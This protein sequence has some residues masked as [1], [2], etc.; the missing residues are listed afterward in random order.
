MHYRIDPEWEPYI[1]ITPYDVTIDTSGHFTYAEGQLIKG[2]FGGLL[3]RHSD[4]DGFRLWLHEI[5]L[6]Q[7]IHLQFYTLGPTA[8]FIYMLDGRLCFAGDEGPEVFAESGFY[9]L[10]YLP[11]GL[12]PAYLEKGKHTIIQLELSQDL[13]ERV[14]LKHI[15]M[16][17]AWYSLTEQAEEG[18]IHV[19]SLMTEEVNN[20]LRRML[21]CQIEEKERELH[22]YARFIDL[23]LLY[24]EYLNNNSLVKTSS[25]YRFTHDDF[26]AIRAASKLK[27]ENIDEYISAKDM[28]DEALLH[29]RKLK[30]GFKE[31]YGMTL[32]DWV[33]EQKLQHASDQLK[34]TNKTL[35]QI[36]VAC[37]YRTVSALI[38]AF[39]K[40][41]GTTP[42]AYRK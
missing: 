15:E 38:K 2:P 7:P 42:A 9:Y 25:G 22:Q 13:L 4:E 33:V 6:I 29:H 19:A 35:L 27:L 17:Q 14:A 8:S 41:F 1:T 24:A 26:A 31:M 20:Q 30:A 10:A 11:K 39:K 23:W 36:A 3:K 32:K 18:F 28:A 16:F 40:R 12:M 37:G 21:N 34:K 5:D